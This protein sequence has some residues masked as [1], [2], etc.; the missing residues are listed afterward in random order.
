MAVTAHP[1]HRSA[2]L[3]ED[4]RA[5]ISNLSSSGFTPAQIL[6][7]LRKTDPDIA[8]IP[9]DMASL[10]YHKRLEELKGKTPTP[11]LLG[12]LTNNGFKPEYYPESGT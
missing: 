12:E 7:F 5:L 4:T 11:W 8:L 9:K 3:S 2:A 6:T 1:V 10:T